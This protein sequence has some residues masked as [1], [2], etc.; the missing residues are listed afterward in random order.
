VLLAVKEG[1]VTR[2]EI[3]ESFGIITR[4]VRK[5]VQQH[6]ET[7]SIE[8]LPHGGGRQAKFTPERLERLKTLVEK[9]PTAT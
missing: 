7:G 6:R 5:L 3:A 9:K 8:P 2:Q 1:V 4:W